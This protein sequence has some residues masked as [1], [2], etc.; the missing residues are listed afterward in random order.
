[1][2]RV[3]I[4]D[5]ILTDIADAIRSKTSSSDLIK[6]SEMAS[7]ISDISGGQTVL[8][9]YVLRPDAT[10]VSAFGYDKYLNASEKVTIPSYSTTAATVLPSATL[11]PT[12]SLDFG[13]YD[14][15]VVERALTIPEYS[16]STKA[17]G[18]V[19]Y[20]L[21]SYLCELEYTPAN[22]F[23]AIIDPT[24]KYTSAQVTAIANN[25]TRLVYYSS[26]TAITPYSSAGYGYAA[27]MQA[28]SVTAAGVLTLKTPIY[29][30]RG[31]TTY[32]VNTFMN[33]VT[34]VRLQW[35]YE[36]YKIPKSNLN[37]DGFGNKQNLQ[38]ILDCI[39]L[40]DHK[41]S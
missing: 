11:S 24:K 40:T 17:K 34:D 41:L 6:P 36:L 26:G 22:T 4:T 35:K 12:I 37:L 3:A 32:F 8:K 20:H 2:G 13:N 23:P 10:L 5:T 18:R 7:A 31:H 9:P 33:A 39:N 14:Y 30:T 25:Y 19:E 29:I 38:K 16:I 27:V 28:P 21:S 15:Y 1:M